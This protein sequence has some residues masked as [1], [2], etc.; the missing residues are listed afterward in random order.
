MALTPPKVL[1]VDIALVTPILDWTENDGSG[2][3]DVPY[4]Y[5]LHISV[6][7]QD[8]SHGD[9][10]FSGLDLNV[11]DWISNTTGGAALR[12]YNIVSQDESA[13]EILVEDEDRYSTM[14]D[15]S[16]AGV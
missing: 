16:Q 5:R 6:V 2:V 1:K 14:V 11:G 12:I 9:K 8:H 7:G 4:R 3:V 10:H 13:A 15:Q